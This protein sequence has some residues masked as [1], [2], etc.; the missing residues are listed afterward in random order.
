[1]TFYEQFAKALLKQTSAQSLSVVNG[2]VGIANKFL[3]R[4]CLR[5]PN[6]GR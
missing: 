6:R 1:M 4:V 3:Y 2:W 5:Y